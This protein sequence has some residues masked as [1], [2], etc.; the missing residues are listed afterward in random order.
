MPIRRSTKYADP[1]PEV[2]T[3]DDLAY[4]GFALC[5]R[6]ESDDM[7]VIGKGDMELRLSRSE[8]GELCRL[9]G[10]GRRLA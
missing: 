2:G 7:I 9:L 5:V 8:A 6:H 4:D 3:F 1:E 10:N